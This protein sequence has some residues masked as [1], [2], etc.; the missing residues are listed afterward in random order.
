[1]YR[2][3]PKRNV[4]FSQLV[5]YLEGTCVV[6]SP[7]AI[8][9]VWLQAR[10]PKGFSQMDR[11]SKWGLPI[12]SRYMCGSL[13]EC[14]S[15]CIAP[16]KMSKGFFLSWIRNPS[17]VSRYTQGTWELKSV[18]VLSN[19]QSFTRCLLIYNR[20]CEVP[21]YIPQWYVQVC[22]IYWRYVEEPCDSW[23]A[24][25]ENNDSCY[26]LRRR[27]TSLTYHSNFHT[28]LDL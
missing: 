23:V 12:Y 3:N 7:N 5:I 27:I 21:F 26:V 4:K 20:V 14:C 19:A 9:G 10:W 2:L 15:W 18:V 25:Q 24:V 11:V 6:V 16:N 22:S 13:P 28:I 1:M 17:R 8:F